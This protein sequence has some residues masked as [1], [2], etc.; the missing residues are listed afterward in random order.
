MAH[1]D[2]ERTRGDRREFEQ[3]AGEALAKLAHVLMIDYLRGW[4]DATEDNIRLAENAL[5]KIHTLHQSVALAHVAE[6]K[7]REVRGDLPGEIAALTEALALNPDLADAYAHQ[8]N[9]WVLLGQAEKALKVLTE[10]I[11]CGRRD[12]EPGLFSWFM[13]RAYFSLRQYDKAIE[14]LEES[15]KERPTTWFTHAYL[16]SA[17][18]LKNPP[19]TAKATAAVEVYKERF[20]TNWPLCP[21][22]RNYYKQAKYRH[23][24]DELQQALDALFDGLKIAKKNVGFP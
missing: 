17:C 10:A 16:I 15:V 12:P 13:G 3:A 2:E 4:N 24:P 6:A 14:Q 20:G 5:E 9:A 8:A 1:L 11:E 23:A 21:N 7:I 19:E 22:I 18:F